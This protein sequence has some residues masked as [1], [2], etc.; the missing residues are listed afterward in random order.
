M[1]GS[2]AALIDAIEGMRFLTA[3]DRFVLLE[4]GTRMEMRLNLQAI[5]LGNRLLEAGLPGAVETL[6][7]FVS[8]LVHYDS[9]ELPLQHLQDTIRGL[10]RE[11]RAEHDVTVPSRL[12]ELPVLYQDPWTRECVESYARTIKP[13]EDNPGFVARVNGLAGPEQVIARHTRTE[14]WIGGVGF[15]PGQADMLPLDPRGAL[16]VPK[17]NPPRLWTTPG[18]VGV[19]GGFT[20]I[21]PTNSPG[22]YYLLG[23]TPAPI[24]SMDR[25]LA[26]FR[27]QATL[28]A[29]GDRVRFRPIAMDEYEAIAAEVAAGIYQYAITD[30]T[31]FSLARYESWLATIDAVPDAGDGG[32]QDLPGPAQER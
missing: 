19:G 5:Q 15:R 6:P 23:R 28:L 16:S 21:Y 2:S 24:Y 25:R 17:Y 1:D 27:S 22:G 18:A 13:I 32:G 29:P 26:P 4:L 9:L 8:V 30:Y 7:M 31:L 10:W 11:I 12:V 20:S 3:G 14:H